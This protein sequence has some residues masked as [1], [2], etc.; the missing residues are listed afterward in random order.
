MH[1]TNRKKVRMHKRERAE[2]EQ[3]KTK[4]EKTEEGELNAM[5]INIIIHTVAFVLG[6]MT[7]QIRQ[8]IQLLIV[9]FQIHPI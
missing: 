9:L 8:G 1:N 4:R 2:R 6:R 7:F 3:R 5:Y